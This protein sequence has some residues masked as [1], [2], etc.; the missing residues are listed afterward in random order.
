MIRKIISGARE[1]V[2]QAALDVARNLYLSFG[3]WISRS[4]A[5]ENSEL[6]KNCRL[7]IMDS[8]DPVKC[9]EHNILESDGVLIITMG[10]PEG[11]ATTARHLAEHHGIPF[12]YIDM[13][14]LPA[15]EAAKRIEAWFAEYSIEVL[16]ITGSAELPHTNVHKITTDILEVV[17]QLHL[18]DPHHY[19]NGMAYQ[20]GD[21]ERRLEEFI[22]IP[23]T[24]KEAVDYLVLK[25]N[26]QDR[27][28]IANMPEKRLPEL[29][30]ALEDIIRD[31]FRLWGANDPLIRDCHA[32]AETEEEEPEETITRALWLRLRKSDKVLRVVK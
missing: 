25:L 15:F 23:R 16:C 7:N 8:D 30:L 1:G 12:L 2:E 17:F 18:M 6:V 26:F 3:G 27:T 19:E 32:L 14:R 29:V 22:R 21:A 20:S 10:E 9:A 4:R 11:N 28:R 13:E 5:Q 24:V 31:E